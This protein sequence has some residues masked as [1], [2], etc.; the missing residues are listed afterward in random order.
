MNKTIN[1]PTGDLKEYT[2]EKRNYW[3]GIFDAVIYSL[4]LWGAVCILQDLS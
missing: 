3:P 1:Q 4:A 2:Q